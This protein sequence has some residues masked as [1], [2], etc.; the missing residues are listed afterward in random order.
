MTLSPRCSVENQI[1]AVAQEVLTGG[2]GLVEGCR[3]LVQ[4]VG[5]LED[6]DE[7]LLA[8]IIGLESETDDLPL[9]A[10][11]SL[12]SPTALAERQRE[13]DAYLD[14]ARSVVLEACRD[15]VRRYTTMSET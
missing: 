12:W 15:L 14:Q 8:P 13:V 7:K 10:A 11:R 9:G 2:I 5:S 1:A 4:L 6:W 3:R